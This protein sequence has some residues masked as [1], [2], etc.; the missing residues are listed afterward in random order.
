MDRDKQFLKGSEKRDVFKQRHKLLEPD[1]YATDADLCLISKFPP[2]TVA[3]L[4]YKGSGEGVTFAEAIQYNEW[5]KH[6]PVYVVSGENPET[7]PFLIRRYLGADWKPEPPQV[8]WGEE[9]LAHNWD[10]LGQWEGALREWY[11][12][13]GGWCGNLNWERDNAGSSNADNNG[14]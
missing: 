6:A 13:R 14:R 9:T 7:G 10:E 1:F 11:R 4:D 8:N 12:R 2:G 3:Y 5:M